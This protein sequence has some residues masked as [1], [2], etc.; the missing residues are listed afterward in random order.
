VINVEDE[1]FLTELK[2]RG[3]VLETRP[4]AAGLDAIFFGI[5]DRRDLARVA[6]AARR[7]APTGA[8]W[9]IRAKGKAA[10]VTEAE[11]M[12]AGKGAGLVDVKV[13]SFS[14]THTAEKYVIPVARRARSPR[15]AFPPPRK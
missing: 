14:P 13:V 4:G 11:L 1:R 3:A 6:A 15:S 2:A 5:R 10:V 7:L 8:L 9:T 12:A